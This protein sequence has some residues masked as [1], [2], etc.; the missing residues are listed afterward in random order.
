[1][2]EQVVGV[3][4]LGA[5]AHHFQPFTGLH[6][7]GIAVGLVVLAE[8]L[9]HRHAQ[10]VAQA[11]E[12]VEAGR[13]LGVLDLAQHAL[14]DAGDACHIGELEGLGLALALDLQA[15]VLLQAKARFGFGRH[16]MSCTVSVQE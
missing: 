16:R 14:A 10:Y 11:A 1:M 3:A 4:L 8:Q 12:G 9:G 13:H 15:Q 7:Q 2:I 5:A 6:Q